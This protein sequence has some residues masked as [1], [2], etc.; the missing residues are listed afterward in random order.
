MKKI[1]LLALPIIAL[2]G[3]D[4]YYQY[5][6]CD[7][8]KNYLNINIEGINEYKRLV[9]QDQVRSHYKKIAEMQCNNFSCLH[10][11]KK[12]DF[13]E[14]YIDEPTLGMKGIYTISISSDKQDTNCKFKAYNSD[15]NCYIVNKNPDDQI[16]SRFH[17]YQYS[18]DDAL[19]RLFIDSFTGVTLIDLSLQTYTIPNK[20]SGIGT[21]GF[22]P[23]STRPKLD[24]EINAL[25]YPLF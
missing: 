20:I 23:R 22:C 11:Y 5:T 3:C 14:T 15:K 6:Q 17:L 19:R 1:F 4:Y 18:E 13:Y 2:S 24:Y 9:E 8:E 25:A 21:G 10:S 12:G 7:P 16:K